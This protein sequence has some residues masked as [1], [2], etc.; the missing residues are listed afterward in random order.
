VEDKAFISGNVAIHQFVKIGTLAMI[1]GLARV[2]KDVMPYMLIEG[3]SEV[4]A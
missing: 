4:C 1:G 2:N 3:D